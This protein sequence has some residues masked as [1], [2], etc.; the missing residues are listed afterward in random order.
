MQEV[1]KLA[2]V[3]RKTGLTVLLYWEKKKSTDAERVIR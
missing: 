2:R 1:K 3:N